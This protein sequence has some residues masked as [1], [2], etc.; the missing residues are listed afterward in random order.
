MEKDDITMAISELKRELVAI[1]KLLTTINIKWL[2]DPIRVQGEDIKHLMDTL[3]GDMS[4]IL[5][6]IHSLDEGIRSV[7]N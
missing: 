5:Y 2:C 3:S 7:Y 1:E 4:T 6:D